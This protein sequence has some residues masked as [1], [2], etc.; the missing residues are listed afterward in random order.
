MSNYG[1]LLSERNAPERAKGRDY[2]SIHRR[3]SQERDKWM[4][5]SEGNRI[6]RSPD[7]RQG[8]N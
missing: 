5:S 1:R 2:G 8:Y 6:E 3:V 4:R 7:H